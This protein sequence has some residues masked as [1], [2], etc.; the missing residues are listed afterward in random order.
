MIVYSNKLPATALS[1]TWLHLR[2]ILH[3]QRGGDGAFGASS[4]NRAQAQRANASHRQP[5]LVPCNP[6]RL[7][8]GA[9]GLKMHIKRTREARQAG[10][11]EAT[12]ACCPLH[13]LP[14]HN[15]GTGANSWRCMAQHGQRRDGD[16]LRVFWSS[17]HYVVLNAGV[18]P[19]LPLASAIPLPCA[20]ASN[21]A[22]HACRAPRHPTSTHR[23]EDQS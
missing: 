13:P 22:E 15:Q 11:P 2:Y 17:R 12:G 14:Q 21:V 9:A 1:C 7:Q 16:F 18:R 5:P 3:C 10:N 19:Q 4:M 8:A 6:C 23:K 20:A